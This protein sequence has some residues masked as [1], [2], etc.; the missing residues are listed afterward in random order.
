MKRLIAIIFLALSLGC[1]AQEQ[2]SIDSCITLA[3][4]NNHKLAAVRKGVDAAQYDV[5]HAKSYF[6]PSFSATG[7]GLYSTA[8]GHLGIPGQIRPTDLFRRQ[9]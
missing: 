5:R 9:D 2:M 8:N 4:R 7:M 1:P 6:F 3:V